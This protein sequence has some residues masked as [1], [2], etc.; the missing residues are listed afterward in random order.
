MDSKPFMDIIYFSFNKPY[1]WYC[2]ICRESRKMFKAMSCKFVRCMLT[3][4]HTFIQNLVIVPWASYFLKFFSKGPNSK[5]KN[6]EL[7]VSEI[8]CP[9]LECVYKMSYLIHMSHQSIHLF[10]EMLVPKNT[11]SIQPMR[12]QILDAWIFYLFFSFSPP[13]SLHASVF[14]FLYLSLNDC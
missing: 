8:S 13:P 1:K 14:W 3:S 10:Y 2:T 12:S 11:K 6:N 4:E 9:L 7:Q 5:K